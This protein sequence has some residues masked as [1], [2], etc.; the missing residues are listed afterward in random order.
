ME[1]EWDMIVGLHN[2]IQN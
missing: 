1:I 2:G